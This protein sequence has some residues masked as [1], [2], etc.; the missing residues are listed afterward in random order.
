VSG[1]AFGRAR[2]AGVSATVFVTLLACGSFE[3]RGCPDLER[4]ACESAL[5]CTPRLAFEL[6]G[7]GEARERYVACDVASRVCG[8]AETCASERETGESALFRNTCLPSGW[9]EVPGEECEAIHAAMQGEG[10]GDA[11]SGTGVDASD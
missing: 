9:S 4:D 2:T 6:D 5:R 11:D 8:Q 3:R 7:R 10:V 1:V